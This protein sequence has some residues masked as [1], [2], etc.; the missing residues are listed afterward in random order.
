M[1]RAIPLLALLALAGCETVPEAGA[2][3]C[4][5]KGIQRFIGALGTKDVGRILLKRSGAKTI[6][7]LA[8]GTAATMDYRQDR[9]NVRVDGRNFITGLDCG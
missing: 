8:P 7:W 6:R 1:K 5:T 3:R 4:D 2:G 9:L